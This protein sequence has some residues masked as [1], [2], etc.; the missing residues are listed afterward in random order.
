MTP[1]LKISPGR[2]W[3]F[4]IGALTLV[5]VVLLGGGELL[6]RIAGYGYPPTFLLKTRIQGA[7]Y[8]IPNDQFGFRFFPRSIAR[9][10]IPFRMHALKPSGTIRIFLFGESAALGDPD[11][12]FGLA[13]YL[14]VLL[15]EK[16]Q[17]KKFEVVSGAMT[18][19]NSHV[20][21]PIAREMARYD[22]D[23]WLVYMGNNE[24]IGPYGASTV[25]GSRAPALWMVRGLLAIKSTRLGQLLDALLAMASPRSSAPATWGGMKMFQRHELRAEDPARQRASENFRRNLRDILSVARGQHIPVCVS[26]VASNLKDCPP[27][28]SAHSPA[29]TGERLEQWERAYAAGKAFAEQGKAE[30]AVTEFAQAAEIDPSF[31]ELQFR[32]GLAY[33]SLDKTELARDCLI[34]ARDTDTLAFRSD[35]RLEKIV[36]DVTKEFSSKQVYLVDSVQAI[37]LRSTNGIPGET[38]FYEHVH[39]NFAGNYLLA[40]IFADEIAKHLP[41]AVTA[42]GKAEWAAQEQCEQRLAVT[43]WDQ[44]RLWQ[45]NYSRV[46]EPPFTEQMNDAAR[47]RMYMARLRDLQQRMDTTAQLQARATYEQA[48]QLRPDD[49]FLLS[50][51]SQFLDAIRDLPAAQTQQT[52]VHELLPAFPGPLQKLGLLLVHQGKVTEATNYFG[53]AIKLRPDYVPAL[54]ELGLALAHQQKFADAAAIFA[55]AEKINPGYVETYLSR[56]FM[57]QSAGNLRAAVEDY[58]RAANFQAGG[59]AA[60]FDK[61][62][63]LASAH[64]RLEAAKA[65]QTAVFMNP[66]FWQARYLLGV[67][68]AADEKVEEAAAQFKEVIRLRPDLAKAHFNLGVALGKQRKVEEA[69]NEFRTT[70]LLSPTNHAA[71]KYIET[72]EMLKNRKAP[73]Q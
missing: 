6:L 9:T 7:D 45:L 61:G 48:L 10:P 29:L 36:R 63:T 17:G 4:R 62:V 25:F 11:P 57:K 51:F 60:Y 69:L 70:V 39:F 24:M 19:I 68:L 16:Y 64:Q 42:V 12:S 73:S 55:R 54:N 31:A 53:A 40:R 66:N 49:P 8:L 47:A 5:P 26:T 58:H 13:R 14:E 46:S 37:A 41:S 72:L 21:L 67:E 15:E 50:N 33:L 59:P 1:E 32:L 28:G 23:L 3:L 43:L 35:S 56:G 20:I 18:A 44:Y 30:S 22:A 34:R 2:L 65:F 38:W 71:L 52:K 27:F